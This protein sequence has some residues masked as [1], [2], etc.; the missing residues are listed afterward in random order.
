MVKKLLIGVLVVLVLSVGSFF[1]PAREMSI[2][3]IG[4]L[5]FETKITLSVGSETAYAAPDL[6]TN[7]PSADSG[8]WTN[9]TSAYADGGGYASITSGTPSAS[10]TYSGYGF[11]FTDEQ[12]NQVRVR[13]DA[14]CAGSANSQTKYPTGDAE[15]N[16]TWTLTPA[17]GSRY[18]KVDE[19]PADDSDYIALTTAAG[20][21]SYFSFS[22]F[23]VPSGSTVNNVTVYYR[24]RDT[25]VN[26][27]YVGT[28]NST[29]NNPTSGSFSLPT[30]WAAGDTAVFWWY[31][32][33]NT[34]TFTAPAG[35]TQK[36]QASSSG[37]GRIYIGYRV[38]QSG[39]TTFSWTS[40]SVAN[41]TTI[42]G[43][44]VFRGVDPTGDPFEAQSGAPATFTNS[45]NPN[46]PA[47]TTVSSNAWVIPIFGKN[48]DYTGTPTPPTNYTSAGSNSS[49]S[50]ND[51]SAGVAYRQIA[52]PGSEDPGAWTLGGGANS[53]DGY[54]W[55][56]ALKPNTTSNT[57]AA[58]K[59]NG[60]LYGTTDAGADPTAS[61]ADRNYVFTT[62]P[63]TSAAWTVADI[64]G[65]GANPLQA[66]GINSTDSSPNIQISQCYAVVNYTAADE[67]IRVDVSWD[68]G[69]NWS[70]PQTTNLTGAEATY[71]YDVTGATAW[72]PAKLSDANLRVRVDAYSQGAASEVRLDWIPVEVDY[73]SVA[74][75]SCW[76]SGWAKRTK[77]TIDHNDISAPLTDFPV[78]VYL[79]SASGRATPK[80]DVTFVFDELQNNAN[81][82]KIAVTDS[83]CNQ[84]YVE[85]EKW[86]QASEQ[87]W[88][89]VRVPSIS[90][91]SDTILHLY[92]DKN[93]PD[94]TTYVGDPT[95]APGQTVWSNGFVGVWHLHDTTGGS[96]AIKDSTSNA[97]HGTD[98]GSP[99]LGAAGKIDNAIN[100]DGTDDYIQTTSGESKTA[101]NITWEIWFKADST[102][103]AHHLLWEGPVAQNGWGEPGDA[104]THEMHLTI[105]RYDIADLLDFFYGYEYTQGDFGPAVEIQTAFSDTTSFHY[106]VAVLTGAG[107]SPSGTLYLDGSSV[108][109]DTGTETDRSP[110]DTDLRIGMCGAA[111]RY[112]DGIGDEVRVS[113]TTRDPAWIKASY[114]SERDDLIDFGPE[115]GAKISNTPSSKDFGYVGETHSYWSN[116]AAPT[117]PLDDGECFFTLT[118][119]SSAPADITIRATNFTGGVGWTLAGTPGVN[120]VT[121]KAGRSGDNAEGDMVI[122]TTGD[123]SFIT[124]MPASSSWKWEIELE[125]GT[126]TDNI[127]KT[128]TI[129]LTASIA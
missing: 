6:L 51:A 12:I 119:N 42:W 96:G 53:D 66:F 57:R 106:T 14:W 16:G 37:Y 111:Q 15:V 29:G 44:S 76:L 3:G 39:D 35:V 60:T 86:D 108:G 61:W 7:P 98:N 48:D 41:S 45:R 72:T 93:Q 101:E 65:S 1:I 20:G 94:N 25:A 10:H 67:Q 18:Q 34:K 82:F 81:R 19:T 70:S 59:V 71:W 124:S 31:T 125:T 121:L 2:E 113:N 32:Y 64:N 11:G 13:Y 110:W 107:S 26:I 112:L 80:D 4:R 38:L 122:L 128:S 75:P 23:S 40:G 9:P 17:G 22:N 126:F 47:V 85:I 30:G 89:W 69:T 129:T 87:A 104:N 103:S 28:A 43:T 105:G 73:T 92:Y 62:N 54:V 33:A 99:T 109:T 115:E 118:N 36:Q 27:S 50:G 56:G 91:T 83:S 21:Y 5:S 84:L 74:P 52:N 100:F 102:T 95:S 78:L 114:E 127:L 68:G 123:Q 58:L 120:T 97:H 88:L 24:H 117:F 116:G 77:L 8:G 46:P 90:T 79:S 55:T 49:T 63:A